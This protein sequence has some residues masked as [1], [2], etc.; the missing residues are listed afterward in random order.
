M[1]PGWSKLSSEEIRLAKMWF[2]ED[3]KEPSEIAALLRRDKSTFT[4][5][6]CQELERKKD[7]RPRALTEAQIDRM[8]ETM[9]DMIIKANNEYR[10]TV[11]MVKKECRLKVS[12]KTILEAL[13]DRDIYFRPCRDKPD[14]TDQDVCDRK[15]FGEK[16][17][18]KPAT[19]WTQN[20]QMTIDVKYFKIY[21]NKAARSRA[22]REGAWG[23]FRTKAQ[24]L[25][26]QYVRPSKR[27]KWNPG[28]RGVHVLAGVGN[29]RVLLWEYIDGRRWS[30]AVAAEMY[31]GPMKTCLERAYPGRTKWT[32]LEDNDPTGFRSKA[33]MQAKAETGIEVLQIPKRSPQLNM[34]DYALWKEVEKRMRAQEK[35]FAPSFRESRRAFLKRLRRTAL[36][37]PSSFISSSLK[38]MKLRCQRLVAAEGGHIEEGGHHC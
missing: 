22:A 14:L 36:R 6:L 18:E 15:A 3:G 5:L 29:G 21:T 17:A 11:S 8:V 38:N 13:H 2:H 31:K 27:L 23:S 28:A 12:E 26:A 33:G 4:R 16:Y 19:F 34:C 32:I 25:L 10:I 1:A 35:R 9:E 24:G 37:L 7:G 20:V 30:G